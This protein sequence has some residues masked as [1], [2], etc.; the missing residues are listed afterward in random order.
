MNIKR[1]INLAM[2]RIIGYRMSKVSSYEDFEKSYTEDRLSTWNNHDFVNDPDFVRAYQRG[3]AATGTDCRWRWRV[4]F[5]LWAASH[6]LHLDGAFVECGV[7][8]GFLSSA[9]MEY[10][11]WNSVDRQF[12]LFDTFCGLDENHVTKEEKKVGLLKSYAD[13]YPECYKSVKHNFSEFKNVHLIRGC[14]PETL[15]QVH[16]PKVSYLSIDMNCVTPEIAAAEHFWDKLVDGGIVLLDDYGGKGH[17][18]QKQAFDCFAADKGVRVLSSP[19]GQGLL[20]K[21]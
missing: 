11:G 8:R 19:T 5:G 12:Y 14:V 17:E 20:V 10:L 3:I 6:A 21:P 18:M 2:V 9:I 16:I 13:A 7:N 4:H 1:A 15:S